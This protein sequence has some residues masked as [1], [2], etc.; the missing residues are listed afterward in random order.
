MEAVRHTADELHAPD[1]QA[2]EW[3]L[4]ATIGNGYLATRMDSDIMYVAGVFNGV[5]AAETD[6]SSV[7]SAACIIAG[8]AVCCLCVIGIAICRR[9]R[10]DRAMLAAVLSFSL[11]G[12]YWLSFGLAVEQ[13][14]AVS[15]FMLAPS[16]HLNKWAIA[17]TS[18]LSVI[19][20][21]GA[22]AMHLVCDRSRS[23]RVSE[24]RSR[25]ASCDEGAVPPTSSTL[26]VDGDA[27]TLLRQP[28]MLHLLSG[29]QRGR[30]LL[31]GGATVAMG[32]LC[33]SLICCGIGVL[34]SILHVR[35]FPS[36]QL[37]AWQAAAVF[38]GSVTLLLAGALVKIALPHASGRRLCAVFALALLNAIALL[39]A[40]ANGPR[41]LTHRAALPNPLGIGLCAGFVANGSTLDLRGAR[42]VRRSLAPGGGLAEQRWYA[43]RD[44]D[45]S[46]LMVLEIENVGGVNISCQV[47]GGLRVAVATADVGLET[48]W[49]SI[50]LPGGATSEV[51]VLSGAT[52]E[53]ETK[54]TP[55]TTVAVVA[56]SPPTD[57]LTLAPGQ[58]AYL[59]ASVATSLESTDPVRSATA[60]Y[61]TAFPQA[62]SLFASHAAA[63]SELW[64]SGL[65]VEGGREDVARAVNSSLYY[66][67]SS[68]RED[69]PYSLSPGGLASD[70][71]EPTRS[72]T[73]AQHLSHHLSPPPQPNT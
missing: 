43:H 53:M 23:R 3:G 25:G 45:R 56:T 29:G 44:K 17:F 16:L 9:E 4:K 67:L 10:A 1:D 54:S 50:P 70:A 28:G 66:I 47:T 59:L 30:F 12:A 46:G 24:S 22:V 15:R 31:F 14:W 57:A 60:A 11:L 61:R 19:G 27:Q 68:I 40:A 49:Q 6:A 35:P 18:V 20:A 71:C 38:A 48:Q 52:Y 51:M 34:D 64:R 42:Y 7:F 5:S 8:I 62:S 37:R 65:E 72:T 33:A 13:P 63:W 58:S 73:S 21:S 36:G 39:V 69:T 26:E 2:I 55:R 32:L 41:V